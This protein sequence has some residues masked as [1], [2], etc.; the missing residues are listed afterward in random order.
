MTVPEVIVVA[1]GVR[2]RT[3]LCTRRTFLARRA[4]TV[5]REE[6]F[7]ERRLTTQQTQNASVHHYAQQGLDAA[8]HLT[9]HGRA[10]HLHHRDA[11]DLCKVRNRPVEGRLDE[12]GREVPHLGER[13]ISTRTPSRKI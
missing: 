5:V 11:G 9:R 10:G 6:E 13:P 8:L 12:Q 1:I 4:V 3:S 2:S 7:L